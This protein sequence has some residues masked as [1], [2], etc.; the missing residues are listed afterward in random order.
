MDITGNFNNKREA[1]TGKEPLVVV[2]KHTYRSKNEY[3]PNLYVINKNGDKVYLI[4][5]V[6]DKYY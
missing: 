1:D 4:P 6:W 5:T 3:H 2:S